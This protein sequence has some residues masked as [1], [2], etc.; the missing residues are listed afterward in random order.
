MN[1]HDT[2]VR[3]LESAIAR[4][5]YDRRV[6]NLR[7]VTDLFIAGADSFSEEHLAVFDRLLAR[8]IDQIESKVLAEIGERLAL[9]RNAPA[10]VVRNLAHHDEIAVAGPILIRSQQLAQADLVGIAETKSQAHLMAISNRSRVEEAVTDVLV[11]RGNDAVVRTLAGN[12]GAKFSE[13]GMGTLA[14]R[15]EGDEAIAEKVVQRADVPA[16]VFCRLLVAATAVVRERLL[17][18]LAPEAQEE[19]FRTLENVS[20]QIADQTP[21]RRSYAAAIRRVLIESAQGDLGEQDVIRYA[22]NKQSD[23]TIAALSLLSAVPTEKIDMFFT[24]RQYE[25]LLIVCKAAGLTWPAAR[26]VV[27]MNC[28]GGTIPADVLAGLNRTFEQLKGADAQRMLQR[29]HAD[30]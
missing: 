27:Q 8:L 12:S 17:A 25:S 24:R 4:A 29:W 6:E 11:R 21:S 23:E 1:V 19:A 20:G 13:A 10:G 15:A 9:V 5:S 22:S 3:T 2:T 28:P 14:Q 16:H 7:R 18:V 26:A 30:G